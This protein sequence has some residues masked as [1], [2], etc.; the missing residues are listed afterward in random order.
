MQRLKTLVLAFLGLFVMGGGAIWV[1]S[2]SFVGARG[3]VVPEAR[4]NAIAQRRLGIEIGLSKPFLVPA[5]IAGHT[6]ETFLRV[7]T[8]TNG[9]SQTFSAI[10][11]APK[12]VGDTVE[13]TVSVISGDTSIIKTCKDWGM[14]KESRITSYTLREGEEATVSQLSNLGPNFKNGTVTFKAVLFNAPPQPDDGGGTACGC[15]RCGDLEC[16][17]NKGACLGCGTCGDVC[18][19]ITMME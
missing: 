11:L 1:S 12:M 6:L 14:L 9:G 18:C 13:V 7:P 17:P 10:K 15:G 8:N 2:N 4:S 16:C 3:K 19:R 5:A